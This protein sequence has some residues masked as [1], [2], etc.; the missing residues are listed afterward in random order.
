[1]SD[2]KADSDRPVATMGEETEDEE[3]AI[4]GIRFEI[5]TPETSPHE[6]PH[7]SHLPASQD[8]HKNTS[9]GKK[10]QQS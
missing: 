6:K 10:G 3:A 2:K 5:Y 9:S 1:M 7:F 4:G 8:G